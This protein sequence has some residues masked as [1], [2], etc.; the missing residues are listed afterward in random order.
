MPATDKLIAAARDSLEASILYYRGNPVGTVAAR[1]PDADALNYDQCFVRDFVP[2]ALVFLIQG[3]P[4]IVRNF[5]VAVLELQIRERRMDCFQ[6]GQGLLPASFKVEVRDGVESLIGDF[7]EQ[8]IARVAPIDSCFWWLIVLRA[9]VKATGDLSL[10]YQA[11]FQ[12]GMDLILQLCLE[13]RFDLFPTL[14]VPDGSFMIDR[15]M[16]VYGYPL[17]IQVLLYAALRSL[18]ELLLPASPYRSAVEI[19]LNHLSYHVRAYYW[20]DLKRLNEI[21]RYK[22][23]EFGAAVANQFNIY[24]NSIPEWSI[25]WLNDT[26]G[27]LAGNLGPGQIDFRFFG[28]GNLMAVMASLATEDQAQAII[29]LVEYRWDDLVGEMP[30]KICFPAL[31]GQDWRMTT[32]C[33]PKNTPWSYHNGGSWPVLLWFLTA[34]ALKTGRPELAYNALEIA[35]KRLSVDSWSEY[36]DGRQG[37]LIGKVARKFQTWTI[38]AVLLSQALLENPDFLKFIC[39]DADPEPMS[40]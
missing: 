18:R 16:G 32:G 10:A 23:E 15:R 1:D 13:A 30:M 21:Y 27:Y 26:S 40:C 19:R 7:G 22:S 28:L 12:H 11:D 8:A 29:Q 37:K 35:E 2:A 33:D 38:A 14:L 24:P 9:Y 31:E 34:A 4:E 39:F 36:Y 17:E 5:L 6:P 3:R 20:I 25:E